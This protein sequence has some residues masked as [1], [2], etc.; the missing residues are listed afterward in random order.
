MSLEERMTGIFI[1]FLNT[2]TGDETHL[3][4]ILNP[5]SG[6]KTST[7]NAWVQTEPIFRESQF[8]ITVRCKN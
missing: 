8:E 2:N 4:C 1:G 7:A 6:D 3:L 5:A